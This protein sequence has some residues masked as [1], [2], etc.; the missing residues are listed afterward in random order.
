MLTNYTTSDR[1]FVGI[2][3]IEISFVFW[4]YGRAS[5]EYFGALMY[6]CI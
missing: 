3:K 2:H 1:P 5:Y 4:I 6:V